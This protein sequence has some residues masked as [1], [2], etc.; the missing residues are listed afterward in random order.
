MWTGALQTLLF[1]LWSRA[2][3]YRVL[4]IEDILPPHNISYDKAPRT[5]IDSQT[6]AT[7]SCLLVTRYLMYYRVYSNLFCDVTFV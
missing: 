5:H 4:R 6:V 1:V 7:V 3:G 2:G